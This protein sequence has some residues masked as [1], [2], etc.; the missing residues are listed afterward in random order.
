M[1][2]GHGLYS[3]RGLTIEDINLEDMER[4]AHGYH[5]PLL[6]MYHFLLAPH[7]ISLRF[8]SPNIDSRLG[9]LL[10]FMLVLFSN[11][12]HQSGGRKE[13]QH[14]CNGGLPPLPLMNSSRSAFLPH[15]PQTSCPPVLLA[16]RSQLL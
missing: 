2:M 5:H 6:C 1:A 15:E 16:F 8:L 13:R 3:R 9:V 7:N 4:R 11:L 10:S 12:S 14:S